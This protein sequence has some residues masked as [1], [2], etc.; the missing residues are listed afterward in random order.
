[1]KIELNEKQVALIK[2][3]LVAS[4]IAP[5]ATKEVSDMIYQIERH[6][7]EEEK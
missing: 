2:E 1:M 7:R 5:Q 3:L 6:E 4:A